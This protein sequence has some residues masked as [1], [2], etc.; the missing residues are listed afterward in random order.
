MDSYKYQQVKL[1]PQ[2]LRQMHLI[3]LDMLLEVDRICR[4]YDINYIVSGGTLLGAV[5]NQG[6]IP[7][8]DDIDVRMLRDDYDKF[9]DVCKNELDKD[10][11]FLQTHKTDPNYIW[12]YGKIR[13]KGTE[14]VRT[15]QEHL[16]MITG[17]FIDIIS[18]DKVPSSRIFM[19]I[20]CC[21]CFVAKKILYSRVGY[22][23]ERNLFFRLIYL[24][25]HFIPCK[26]AFFCLDSLS[27]IG[28]SIDSPIA[29]SFAF[30]S[31]SESKPLIKWHTERIE[32]MFEGHKIFAPK[33]YDGWLSSNYGN[34]Y[35]KLPPIEERVIHNTASKLKLL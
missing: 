31:K 12:Y 26:F 8:D 16:K 1:S 25:L 24:L 23:N 11:Y 10:K 28:R 27:K 29:A 34:N 32:L 30:V 2:Q 4:I 15:G 21:C 5:R 19:N 17:V 7:W 6:F 22:R 9:C 14:Y 35:M 33:D 13:R 20:F 3:Q 18:S